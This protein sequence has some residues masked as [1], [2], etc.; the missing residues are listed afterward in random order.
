MNFIYVILDLPHEA[1]LG[2][3]TPKAD[4]PK[5]RL[6]GQTPARTL[7]DGRRGCRAG[8]RGRESKIDSHLCLL[9][10]GGNDKMEAYAGGTEAVFQLIVFLSISFTLSDLLTYLPITVDDVFV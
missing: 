4:L 1:P 6:Q 3:V 8:S 2:A 7:P 5:A 9:K 10:L